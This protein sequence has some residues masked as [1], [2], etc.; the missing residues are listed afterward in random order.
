[1]KRIASIRPKAGL[2][3][4]AVSL[5][6]AL[7]VSF[8]ACTPDT[9]EK[10]ETATRQANTLVVYE[11]NERLFAKQQ[12]FAAIQAYVP[13]LKSMGVNVLWLMPVHPRGELKSVGS[14]YCVKDYNAIDPAFGTMDDLRALVNTCHDNGIRVI[15]DWIANHTAWDHPWVKQHPEWYQAAQTAD[16][17]NWNDV[18]FLDYSQPAVHQAMQEAMLYWLDQADIDGFRCDHA[19]GVP[20]DFWKT[21]NAAI[22]AKKNNAILLAEAS[23]THYYDAGFHWLYSWKYLEAIE[24]LYSGTKAPSSLFSVSRSEYTS[25][26]ADKERLRYVTT[27]DETANKA[28][29]TIFTN[30]QGELSAMC[31]TIFLGGVPMIYSSQ[32]LGNMSTINF[33]NYS[34]RDFAAPSA[35][36]DAL[37]QLM[38]IYLNTTDLRNGTQTTGTLSPTVPYIEF[39]DK[40]RSLLVVCNTT[41][42]KANVRY[43]AAYQGA[44]VSNLLTSQ[45]EQ[46]ESST[47]F[48]PFEYRI[49]VTNPF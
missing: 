4:L 36:R 39:T 35:T 9:P 6:T 16:E 8:T 43:P 48:T 14:P 25:T 19:E 27:H 10:P 12:A 37:A 29:A 34:V 23:D 11:C 31:L 45:S 26:P 28:P 46:L 20:T 21:A 41:A 2:T 5:L 49:F 32:E 42:N 40:N 38:Q 17:R 18:T 3:A 30:A 24:G 44:Q 1:M 47:T 15:L 7:A 22:L 13:T 33:F